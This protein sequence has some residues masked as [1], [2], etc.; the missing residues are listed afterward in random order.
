MQNVSEVKNPGLRTQIQNTEQSN[1]SSGV[2]SHLIQDHAVIAVVRVEGFDKILM[3]AS[4]LTADGVLEALTLKIIETALESGAMIESVEDTVFRICW[5]RPESGADEEILD[6]LLEIQ[7]AFSQAN[8]DLLKGGHPQIKSHMVLLCFSMEG[9]EIAHFEKQIS[10]ARKLAGVTS[11]TGPEILV[12][13]LM[14]AS[15]GFLFGSKRYKEVKMPDRKNNLVLFELGQKLSESR[16]GE[17]DEF[18]GTRIE[19][20]SQAGSLMQKMSAQDF[21]GSAA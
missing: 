7:D 17:I 12:D 14:L 18:T 21:G 8:L 2:L 13:E 15:A 9:K 5:D 3:S 1:Q 10:M 19:N 6:T 20:P 11:G 16:E 4:K